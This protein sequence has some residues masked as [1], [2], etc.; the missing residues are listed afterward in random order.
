MAS[1]I[2][3]LTLAQQSFQTNYPTAMLTQSAAQGVA[4]GNTFSTAV[5]FDA[6]AYD[7][8]GGHSNVTNNSRYTI[9]LAGLYAVSVSITYTNSSGL[10]VR[11][12]EVAKNGGGLFGSQA[13]N[14]SYSNNFLTV[15][16]SSYLVQCA[17]NDYIQAFTWQNSGATLNTV[18]NGTYMTVQYLHQ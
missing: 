18:T 7:N 2:E 11:A 14:Q 16:T 13:Y 12:V 1:S 6:T 9:Q 8:W 4:T 5:T 17:V 15:Q 10:L 3:I